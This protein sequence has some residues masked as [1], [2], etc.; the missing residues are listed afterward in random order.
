M[1]GAARPADARIPPEQPA[2]I[3]PLTATE[4][5]NRIKGAASKSTAVAESLLA[6]ANARVQRYA[7]DAPDAIKVEAIVRFAG[8]LA[9]SDFGGIV[10]E[11]IGPMDR[12]F[13]IN[14]ASAFRNSGAAMLL[15]PWRVRRAAAFG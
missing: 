7:P 6:A 10:S 15:S 2:A 13:A 8:Y 14:H 3:P 1:T 12:Q 11:K 9:Q 4:L 5:A